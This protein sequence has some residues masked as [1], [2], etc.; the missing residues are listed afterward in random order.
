MM[1]KNLRILSNTQNFLLVG[2]KFQRKFLA[3]M[4]STSSTGT[5]HLGAVASLKFLAT[6][7]MPRKLHSDDYAL[8]GGRLSWQSYRIIAT[9]LVVIL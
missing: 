4:A 5:Y 2:P 3:T 1:R 6:E 8:R 7:K 9:R